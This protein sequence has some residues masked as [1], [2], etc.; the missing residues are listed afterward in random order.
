MLRYHRCA[1]G[2]S[3]E[4]LAERSGLSTTAIG[5][6]ERGL[7]KAPRLE[8]I[9][10]LV[11][12]LNLSPEQGRVLEALANRARAR[13][14]RH[15]SAQ[16]PVM[17]FVE[18][19]Q[20]EAPVPAEQTDNLPMPSTSFIAREREI[21]QLRE[22]ILGNDARLVTITGTGGV[23]KTR[24]ALET[25]RGIKN[26]FVD[27]VWLVELGALEDPGHVAGAIASVLGVSERG[28]R[29]VQT[30][31]RAL[32]TRNVL[33]ILDN[34][35]HVLASAAAVAAALTEACPHVR[36]L[37]TSRELL[38]VPAERTCPL[39]PLHYSAVRLE[40]YDAAMSFPAVQL[41]VRRAHEQMGYDLEIDNDGL[42]GITDIVRSVDGLP[43]AIELAVA[44]LRTLSVSELAKRL[45]ERFDFLNTGD[46][47]APAR[48]QTL[49]G[50]MGWSFDRL[51]ADEQRVFLSCAI[52][53]G[54]FTT[55]AVAAVC[56]GDDLDEHKVLTLFASLVDKSLIV[57]QG[58]AD[59][60][61]VML[62]SIRNFARYV[63]P[64]A[65]RYEALSR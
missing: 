10:L 32:R 20:R 45:R 63:S 24:L 37:A 58:A 57:V 40:S 28:D 61:C 43:L 29:P 25:A 64:D 56:A 54:T 31:Q 60:R 18:A 36:I 6:I 44:S 65:E 27:G 23:G 53:P 22:L 33:L 62:D 47:N 4:Y 41:F 19:A 3:Q 13:S 30:L 12:A 2:F 5:I 14:P 7:R 50:L 1:A 38:R 39:A 46:R 11:G 48:H 34:C 26:A 55:D 17:R 59:R 42:I 9:S 21:A 16:T 49:R 35:E 52:F 8:T 15:E 51:A